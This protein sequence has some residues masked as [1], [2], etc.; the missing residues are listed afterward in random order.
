MFKLED[1]CSIGEFILP[2]ETPFLHLFCESPPADL[3][4]ESK[5]SIKIQCE[6]VLT[7]Y[8]QTQFSQ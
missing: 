1:N 3:Q 4:W 5:I 6:N 7:S 2:A 8:Y